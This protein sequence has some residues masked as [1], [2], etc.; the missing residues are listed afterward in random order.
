MA[1]MEIIF[2]ILCYI[3]HHLLLYTDKNTYVLL[4]D[5]R[6][7]KMEYEKRIS[8]SR[9]DISNINTLYSALDN[10]RDI[11]AIF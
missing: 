10:G 9:L 2:C 7:V 6:M 11:E 1:T 5:S 8:V 4:V 3:S